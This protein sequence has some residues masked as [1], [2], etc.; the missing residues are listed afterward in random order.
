MRPK[1]NTPQPQEAVSVTPYPSGAS[2]KA[3][4]RDMFN[5]IARNYDFLNHFL[6]L[7]TDRYWRRVASR[8]L[9]SSQGNNIL[10]VATGTADFALALCRH[11]QAHITGLDL[12]ESMLEIGRRK[13]QHQG[14]TERISLV[15]G[16]S[17]ELP[18]PDNHFDAVTAA[19]GVRNFGDL[20]QG[21][22]E[23]RRVLKPSG[24]LVILEFSEPS[25]WLFKPIFRFYFRYVL[26]TLARFFTPDKHAYSYL[27][28]SA[29]AFPSGA[30][31]LQILSTAG[32]QEP[33]RK[34][35]TFGVVSVYTAQK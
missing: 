7:G 16:D 34:K 1:K 21:L 5:T 18:F 3:Q 20:H 13:I 33:A 4:V 9:S 28:R 19:F 17:E 23:M 31:F 32:F 15:Q 27:Q 25:G 14:V 30:A 6:S 26:P 12:S 2:K 35:L 10:D 11:T 22:T 29:G 24:I 8:M